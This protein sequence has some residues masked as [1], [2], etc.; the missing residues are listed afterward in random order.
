MITAVPGTEDTKMSDPIREIELQ[1]E[2]EEN[3]QAEVEMKR[4]EDNEGYEPFPIE[5]EI[6][7]AI[8]KAVREGVSSSMIAEAIMAGLR[9]WD[10]IQMEIVADLLQDKAFRLQNDK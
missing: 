7:M 4:D 9:K 3:R 6:E 8:S 5:L 1:Q 10:P 2:F